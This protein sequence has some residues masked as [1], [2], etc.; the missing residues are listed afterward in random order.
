MS[1]PSSERGRSVSLQ[2][3]L[4]DGSHVPTPLNHRFSI[5]VDP[6]GINV[7]S[8][9]VSTK[10]VVTQPVSTPDSSRELKSLANLVPNRI[11]TVL[12]A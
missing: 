5:G 1:N 12:E 3:G 4:Y 11:G 8:A 9:L 10:A 2:K 7:P 6:S